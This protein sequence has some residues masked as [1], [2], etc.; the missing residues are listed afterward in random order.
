MSFPISSLSAGSLWVRGS[1]TVGPVTPVDPVGQATGRDDTQ[2]LGFGPAALV[3]LSEQ[4]RT[5]ASEQRSAA[6]PQVP[7][8]GARDA[9]ARADSEDEAAQSDAARRTEGGGAQ[10]PAETTARTGAPDPAEPADAGQASGVFQDDGADGST[11]LEQSAAAES[12]EASD[13]EGQAETSGAADPTE[14]SRQEQLEVDNLKKRDRE[15]RAHERAHEAVGGSYT[16]SARY[17]YTL[18]PDGKRYAIAGEV[19]I[20]VSGVPGD[21]EATIRKMATVRRAARAPAN[22]SG[23]DL[24]IAAQAAAIERRA[25][26]EMAQERYGTAQAHMSSTDVAAMIPVQSFSTVG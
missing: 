18:G 22:P 4:A 19:P 20:D 11:Q 3:T 7:T 16:G 13:S 25:R 14:L 12:A 6:L 15:V 24:Q 10:E 5:L 1:R 8:L 2:I 17:T 21:P 26:A 23:P 9:T